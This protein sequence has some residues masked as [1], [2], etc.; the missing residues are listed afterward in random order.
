MIPGAEVAPVGFGIELKP[1]AFCKQQ[2]HWRR[3]ILQGAG[4][5]GARNM[6]EWETKKASK[7]CGR[8]AEFN[9]QQQ[10]S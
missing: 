4:A 2:A 9:R 8:T 5:N 7:D 10:G 3:D 6:A 1:S